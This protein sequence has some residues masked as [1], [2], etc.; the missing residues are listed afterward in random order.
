MQTVKKS[1]I[2][3]RQLDQALQAMGFTVSSGINNFGLPLI[4]YE[5]TAEDAV[6]LLRGGEDEELVNAID[7]L[8][9]ER[10]IEGRGVSSQ[11]TFYRLLS[12]ASTSTARAA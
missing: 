3:Y 9:A 5:K 11:E 2:T 1:K 7:L 10:T 8:S 12:D 4:R 6:I